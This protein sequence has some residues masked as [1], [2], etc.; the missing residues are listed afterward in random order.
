MKVINFNNREI[1]SNFSARFE[2]GK[3]YLIQ[4]DS[5]SGKSTLALLL[6][7]NIEGCN[8]FLNGKN[9]NM[10]MNTTQFRK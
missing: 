9:I 7:K 2:K 4:G 6:T 10:V 3:K 1:F 8:I 5:G